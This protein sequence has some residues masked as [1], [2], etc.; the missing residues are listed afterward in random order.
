[1][2][3]MCYA[4]IQRPNHVFTVFPEETM[5]NKRRLS[6]CLSL[7]IGV[8]MALPAVSQ[9]TAEETQEI[10]FE[11]IQAELKNKTMTLNVQKTSFRE[12]V[13]LFRQRASFNIVL[14]DDVEKMLTS[15]SSTDRTSRVQDDT[16]FERPDSAQTDWSIESSNSSSFDSRNEGRFSDDGFADGTGNE[17]A[18]P[19]MN[20]KDPL[21]SIDSEV[22][23]VLKD[24]PLGQA[25]K[26]ILNQKQMMAVFTNGVVKIVP[27]TYAE[28]FDTRFYDVRDLLH[29]VK[30]FE[31]PK[32]E[33]KQNEE[34]GKMGV[35]IDFG[36]DGSSKKK[37]ILTDHDDFMEMVQSNVGN[38]GWKRG[39]SIKMRNGVMVVHQKPEVHREISHL[40]TR[41]RQFR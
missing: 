32:M 25:M 8:M 10:T 20:E 26:T 18:G 3:E 28:K 27:D 6:V 16:S 23:I 14:S 37:E 24:V 11:E 12:V 29:D 19:T 33:F 35:E 5:N 34:E 7:V 38:G 41:L 22:S 36:R 4:Q 31:S 15:A 9:N 1:M 39:G 40:L 30:D 13:N 2:T 21:P 17:P